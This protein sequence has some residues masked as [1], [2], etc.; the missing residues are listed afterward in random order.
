MAGWHGGKGSTARPV[1][2]QKFADNWDSIFGKK[3]E[4]AEKLD[5]QPLTYM[6]NMHGSHAKDLT[7]DKGGNKPLDSD[8]E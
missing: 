8:T 4:D 1:N 5:E 7:I 3:K 6:H 2:R